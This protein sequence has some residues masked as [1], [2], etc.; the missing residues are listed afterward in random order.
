M[1]NNELKNQKENEDLI[2]TDPLEN[3]I[4][5]LRLLFVNSLKKIYFAEQILIKTLPNMSINASSPK[6]K[7]SIDEHIFITENQFSRLTQ[8]FNLLDEK[9]QSK[10]CEILNGLQKEATTIL[11]ETVYGPARDAAIISI[12]QKI[13]HYEIATY[14][15]LF[16]FAKVLGENEA[17]KLLQQTLAEESEADKILTDVANYSINMEASKI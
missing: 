5:N 9:A 12:C 6:L 16:A 15:T 10:E 8:I 2:V 11:K 17:A 7:S 1:K 4:A 13:E 3:G 14:G